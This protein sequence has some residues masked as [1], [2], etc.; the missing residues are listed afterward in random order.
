MAA[1]KKQS[2][3]ASREAEPMLFSALNYKILSVGLLLVVVGFTAMY[4]ENKVE[5]VISLYI[6]PVAIMAGYAVVLYAIMKRD[7]PHPSSESKT[8]V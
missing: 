4:L 8:A 6:S 7:H 3:T 5:G 1:K 2:K